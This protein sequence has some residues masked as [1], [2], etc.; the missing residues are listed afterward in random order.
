MSVNQRNKQIVWDYWQALDA[1]PPDS[2]EIVC[3]DC[4]SHDA[5]WR[6]F[7]PIGELS[8]PGEFAS[9]FWRL[10]RSAFP[11]LKRHTWL[12]FGGKSN[13]RID[14]RNDGR[15]WVTGTGVF[16]EYFNPLGNAAPA[17]VDT[18]ETCF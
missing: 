2:A 3:G 16:R 18:F 12:F 17:L 9:G 8:G 5:A 6:G 14:G 11:D 1:N 10:L 15:M 4:M 7:D 13:G